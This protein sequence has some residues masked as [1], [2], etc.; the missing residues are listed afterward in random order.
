MSQFDS[1]AYLAENKDVANWWADASKS[2]IHS[3]AGT[4]T[5]AHGVNTDG[6]EKVWLNDMNKRYNTQHSDV[7]GFTSD[8][9]A[10]HHYARYGIHE[11]RTLRPAEE[12]KPEPTPQPKPQPKPTPMPQPVPDPPK[13]EPRPEYTNFIKDRP[14]KQRRYAGGRDFRQGLYN[15]KNPGKVDEFQRQAGREKGFNQQ[16]SRFNNTESNNIYNKYANANRQAQYGR[17]DGSSIADKYIFKA[18]KSNPIDIV[19]LDKHIRRGP[20]YHEA[21][22]EVAGLLTYGDKYRNSRENPNRWAQPN[23]MEGVESPDFMRF[24]KQSKDDIDN[25]DI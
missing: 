13:P 5:K 22:S 2:G 3:G 25:I 20:M 11:N 23:P 9:Y 7:G 10:R 12:K 17:S 21:K 15:A 6:W 8:Q 16:M 14:K 24:Y 18:D 4:Y 1:N 19:A